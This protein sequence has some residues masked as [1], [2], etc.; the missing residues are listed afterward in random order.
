MKDAYK[1]VSKQYRNISDMTQLYR[2]RGVYV[3]YP[4]ISIRLNIPTGH[5][6]F[7]NQTCFKFIVGPSPMHIHIYV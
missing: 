2:H 3:K 6:T 7:S 1:I 5:K 4:T